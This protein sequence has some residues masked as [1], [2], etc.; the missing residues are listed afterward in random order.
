MA[1][2]RR[3]AEASWVGTLRDGN[4]SIS[5]G[6]GA[7]EQAKY[8]FA[9]RFEDGP[10]TNPEELIA[11]AHA[12]CY[13]MA[14]ADALK[15]KDHPPESITTRAVCTLART[16]DDGFRIH[17]ITLHTEGKVPNIGEA[18]FVE[19]AHRADAECPVSNALRGGPKIEVEAK[20]L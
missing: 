15:R 20:L 3:T 12:A 2:I 10:G 13:S 14:L 4:G 7:L 5:T 17:S 16:A 19:I 8:S 11:G 1:D 9:T 6:S 18:E